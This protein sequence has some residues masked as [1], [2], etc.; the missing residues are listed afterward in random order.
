MISV[1]KLFWRCAVT[2]ATSAMA[3]HL[4]SGSATVGGMDAELSNLVEGVPERFDPVGMRGQLTE[5]QHPTPHPWACGAVA[6]RRVLDAGCGL[7][8][9]SVALA[10]AGA[11]E[12]IGV[13]IAAP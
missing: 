11:A 8:Y 6:G 4:R 13:D 9:G 7:A 3:G 5:A 2:N 10:R 1:K 12:V